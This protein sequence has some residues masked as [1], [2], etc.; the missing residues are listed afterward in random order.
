MSKRTFRLVA[1]VSANNLRAIIRFLE[2][3]F[4]I[5]LRGSMFAPAGMLRSL[6]PALVVPAFASL[7]RA[8]EKVSEQPG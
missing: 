8:V 2:A 7:A 6:L 5:S 1:R 3:G 4:F